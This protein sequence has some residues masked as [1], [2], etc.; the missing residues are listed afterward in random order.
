MVLRVVRLVQV[1]CFVLIH[2]MHD[3]AP[4]RP[5]EQFT[6][7]VLGSVGVC[8]NRLVECDAVNSE[9]GMS[10]GDRTREVSPACRVCVFLAIE[11]V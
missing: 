5:D 8:F 10:S 7:V 11:R 2:N 1:L 4:R 6:K 3:R 9:I